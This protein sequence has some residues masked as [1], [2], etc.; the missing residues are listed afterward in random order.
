MISDSKKFKS[1]E[2]INS[3]ED[4]SSAEEGGNEVES[5]D[6]DAQKGERVN[7]PF[8]PWRFVYSASLEACKTFVVEGVTNI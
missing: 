1:A 6:D 8:S 7:G 5:S 4:D 2:F 3:D